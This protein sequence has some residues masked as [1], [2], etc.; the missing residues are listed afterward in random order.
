[1]TITVQILPDIET[2]IRENASHG[3]IETVR[4]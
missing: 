2:Q 1:M 3:N 4:R